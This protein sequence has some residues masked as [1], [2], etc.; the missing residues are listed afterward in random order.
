MADAKVPGIGNVNR[1]TLIIAGV[2]GLG[3][4]VYA[5]EKRKKTAAAAAA[6]PAAGSAYGYGAY[7]YGYGIG[8]E[9]AQEEALAAGYAYGGYGYA[10]IGGFGIG[11]SLPPTST[12]TPV[13]TNAEWAQFAQQFLVQQGYDPMTVGNALGAYITGANVGAN[14]GI[15]QAAIA[16]EGYPPVA[17]PNNDPPNINTGG[18][19]TGQ[20]GG[21]TGVTN[22][23]NPPANLR[24][25]RNGATGVQVQW[26]PV[27]G[28]TKYTV[29]RVGGQQFTTTNTI[30]NVGG[31]KPNTRYTVQVW[32]DP[33]PTGGPHATLNFTTTK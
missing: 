8:S 10:G 9:L 5:Y 23:A 26:N 2:V 3:A 13:S 7:S 33:T 21:T 12:L 20:G 19:N 15:V 22:A 1:P 29:N 32:G 17:G 24:L 25:V 27:K 16:F 30:G 28:A 6:V 4:A 14:E 31:L 18:P 11:T